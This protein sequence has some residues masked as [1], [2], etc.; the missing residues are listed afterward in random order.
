MEG[1]EVVKFM[2]LKC[3]T[4]F[5]SVRNLFRTKKIPEDEQSLFSGKFSSLECE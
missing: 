1:L 2:E 3:M 5:F 4:A